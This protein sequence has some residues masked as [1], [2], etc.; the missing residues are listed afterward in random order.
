MLR[1]RV[2]RHRQAW[3]EAVRCQ[4]GKALFGDLMFFAATDQHSLNLSGL[5]TRPAFD[6]DPEDHISWVQ[7]TRLRLRRNPQSA[8]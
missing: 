8:R 4:I 2:Q 3:V 6:T 1:V 5:A 7:V